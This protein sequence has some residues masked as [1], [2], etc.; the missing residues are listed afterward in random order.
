MDYLIASG[1]LRNLDV[2]TRL[3]YPE[4]P[5]LMLERKSLIL[6]E[7]TSPLHFFYSYCS[8]NLCT[9]LLTSEWEID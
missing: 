9:Y 3:G 1:L 4:P 8:C 2:L 7:M 6:I 5:P